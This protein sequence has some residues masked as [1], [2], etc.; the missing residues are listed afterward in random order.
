MRSETAKHIV[1]RI[2]AAGTYYTQPFPMVE[3]DD[4][5]PESLLQ[6]IQEDFPAKE[7][8]TWE[9]SHIGEVER[10]RR[11]TWESIFDVPGSIRDV[12]TLLNSSIF[13][14]AISEALNIPKLMPDPYFTGGGLNESFR[15]DYL[16]VHVDGNYHDASGLHRRVN[17]ILYLNDVWEEAWGGCFG[18]YERDGTSLARQVVPSANKLIIFDTSD[19]SYHGYPEPIS[20]PQEVSRRSIILYYYTKSAPHPENVRVQQPHSA[21]WVKRGVRDKH[22]KLTRDFD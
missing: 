3:V 17:A 6:E 16:D 11:S 15:G 19:V 22:N 4:F 13:L 20:C 10:K 21:L 12:V 14:R 1:G 18:V 5:L 7:D 9:T 8:L 2:R